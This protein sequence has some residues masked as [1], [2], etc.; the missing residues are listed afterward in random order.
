M[1][2]SPVVVGVCSM[3][4][5]TAWAVRSIERYSVPRVAVSS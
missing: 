3:L 5:V 4:A 2:G 1:V